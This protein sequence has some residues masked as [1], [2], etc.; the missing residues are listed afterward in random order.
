MWST[1]RAR[2]WQRCRRHEAVATLKVSFGQVAQLVERSPEKAGVGGSSPSLATMFSV[3]CRL[4]LPQVFPH[5]RLAGVCLSQCGMVRGESQL[6]GQCT[7]PSFPHFGP[8]AKS[9]R[10]W[11]TPAKPD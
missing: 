2:C 5:S 7:A 6:A 11:R 9:S 10:L 4:P 8:P 1:R 3:T